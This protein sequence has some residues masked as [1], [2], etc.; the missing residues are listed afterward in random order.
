VGQAAHKL[1]QSNES[2]RSLSVHWQRLAYCPL[3]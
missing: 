3:G 1:S 2:N